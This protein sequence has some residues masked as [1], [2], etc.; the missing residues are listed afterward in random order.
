M[1]APRPSEDRRQHFLVGLTLLFLFINLYCYTDILPLTGEEDRRCLIAQEMLLSGDY[2]HPTVYNVPYYK[3]PPMHNWLIALANLRDGVVDRVSAR[4]VSIAGLL[5]MGLSMYLFL[6]KKRPQGAML[7][8]LAVTTNYLM[9]CEYGNLAETDITV[10]LFTFLSFIFYMANPTRLLCVF[11]SSVFM[12]AGILTKGLS[13]FFFYPAVLAVTLTTKEKKGEKLG[14]LLLHF[15]LSW[16]LPAIWLW[17]FSLQGNLNDL[18]G[19]LTSEVSARSHGKIGALVWHFFYYPG[20]VFFVLLPWSLILVLAYRRRSCRDDVCRASFLIFVLSLVIL[21]LSADG[22]DR[23]LMPAFPAFAIV[24]AYCIDARRLPGKKVQQA[25]FSLLALAG[26]VLALLC[27]LKGYLLQSAIFG[28][29]GMLGLYLRSKRLELIPFSMVLVGYLVVIYMHGLF[30]HRAHYRFDH[31]P[32]ATAIAALIKEPLP[33]V[34]HKGVSNRT[35]LF[36]EAELGR[37]VYLLGKSRFDSYYY[38]TYP[39]WVEKGAENLLRIPYPK[40]HSK[41]LILQRV[42]TTQSRHDDR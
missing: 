16:L 5:I 23:Y 19:R 30:F 39:A 27:G 24:C 10:T 31:E 13:P 14:F 18:L 3:K 41:D 35:G 6:L 22:K 15:V 42:E 9:M 25:V 12:G 4:T 1:T 8:F 28:T 36:L 32:G 2:L 40:D 7:G 17:L 26:F 38:L 11:L 33:V 29:A 37:P 21:T 34:A 20:K